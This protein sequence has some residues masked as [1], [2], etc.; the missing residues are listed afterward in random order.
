M[1]VTAEELMEAAT[2]P[3]RNP[4]PYDQY[5]EST[6]VPVHRG[7]SI[8]DAR[9]VPVGPWAERDCNA[10]FCVLAGQ[11]DVSEV[12]ITEI[13]PGGTTR[14]V[15]FTLDE[16]V[17]V[18]DGRGLTT[19]WAGDGKKLSFEWSKRSIFLIPGGCT[20]QF[21]NTQGHE[22]SRLMHYNYLPT[23]M[24]LRPE[25]E[26]YFNNAFVQPDALY[27]GDAFASAKAME[28]PNERDRQ[29]GRPWWTGNFFP[30]MAVWDKLQPNRNRGAG[31]VSVYFQSKTGKSGHMSVFPPRRYKM[32]H[33]HGPGRVIVIPRGVGYSM[34]WPPGGEKTIV[35]WAEGSVFTPPD[36]W[37]HQHF[38]TGD[39][40]A[41]YIAFNPPRLFN[42]HYPD[43]E[44]QIWYPDEEPW[45][46]E[47][48]EGELA[49]RGL[50]SDVPE[51]AYKDRSYK[52]DY[53]DD[54]D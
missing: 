23:A 16:I 3:P 31:G 13:P 19:I 35:H 17:Y 40:P 15:K 26:F 20:Y 24:L 1:A 53:G 21:S 27:E 11:K 18:V 9:T 25:P 42:G 46:R 41:R 8:E 47:M 54:D 14:P 28:S 33:R 29:M 10:A 7:Y 39:E 36:Q 44:Q 45:I 32:A 52:W 37:Y 5:V 2:R 30:D 34:L 48:F 38:N 50:T 6:G 22:P 43:Q 49:K 12:R 4:S 51:E